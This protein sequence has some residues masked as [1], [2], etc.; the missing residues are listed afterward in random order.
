MSSTI[1]QMLKA[2]GAGE[3]MSLKNH[4]VTAILRLLTSPGEGNKTGVPVCYSLINMNVC[5]LFS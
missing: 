5:C 3:G 1:S 4:E 2:Q